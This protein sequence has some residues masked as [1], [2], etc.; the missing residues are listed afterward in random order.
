M[1]KS[2]NAVAIVL[3]AACALSASAQGK[4][5]G[6]GRAATPKEVA[7]WDIDVRPDFKGLPPGSGTVAKGQDIYEAKCASCHG[8]FGEQNTVF[9][10]L[11]GGTTADDIKTGNVAALK[12]SDYPGRTT[13]MKVANVSTL[14]DYIN[15][16]MPWDKPKS[17][18][19]EEVYAV[20]AF[21]LNLAHVVPDDFTLSN[22]NMGEVQ[23]K[24][25]NRN[26]MT[27]AHGLWPGKE[28]GGT[29][30]P[31]VVATACMSNCGPAPVTTSVLPEH[32]RNNHGN[33]RE[34]NRTVGPQR[35]SD[36]T[37]AEGLLGDAA[38]VVKV[39]APAGGAASPNAA[40]IELTQ[41]YTCTACHSMDSKLVGPSF[42]EIAKKHAGKADYL[43]E[44]IK[45]GSTGAWGEIPMPPQTL[46]DADNKAIAAWLAAGAG[47]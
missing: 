5:P 2:R 46:P 44:K 21:L 23:K 47:K 6:I 20:T 9:T 10:P 13:V 27:T 3:I 15:R 8:V 35:G 30:K 36:T 38:G 29:A 41:K 7:A 19:T 16:A 32:A 33:L 40:V 39:V 26:G 22:Q 43:A 18:T 37:K 45:A 25:P 28:L 14:W 17:L 24:L 31:D 4:F 1:F 11:I 12:R 42:A 34:Q